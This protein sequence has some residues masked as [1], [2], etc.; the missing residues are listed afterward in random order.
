MTRERR[1]MIAMPDSSGGA[2]TAAIDEPSVEH[3]C[4]SDPW[5]LMHKRMDTDAVH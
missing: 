4:T 3:T 2:D 5:H 1:H